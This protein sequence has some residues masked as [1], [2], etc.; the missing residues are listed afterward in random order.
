MSASAAQ[1]PS[2]TRPPMAEFQ[3]ATFLGAAAC[4]P[5]P[6]RANCAHRGD[7]FYAIDIGGKSYL[8]HP[9]FSLPILTMAHIL[10]TPG[11]RAAMSFPGDNVLA[12]LTPGT[13][14]QI[15]LGDSGVDVRILAQSSKGPRYLASRY[16]FVAFAANPGEN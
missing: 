1:V 7:K 14:F 2:F 13:N 16:T 6:Y 11:N 10:L 4:S 9:T 5:D 12:H 8:L 3:D 15:H